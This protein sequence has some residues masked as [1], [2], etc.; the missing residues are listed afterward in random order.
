MIQILALRAPSGVRYEGNQAPRAVESWFDKGLRAPSVDDIFTDPTSFIESVSPSERWNVYYTVSEC[1]EERGRKFSRQWHIPFDVDGIDVPEGIENNPLLLS[2]TARLVCAALGVEFDDT[3]VVYTGNGLQFLIG[4]DQP[5]EDETYFDQA[6][7][8]Y[9]ALCD[10]IDLKLQEHGVRGKADT[11]VW[12]RARLLRYP[13]TLNKKPGKPER[14][15]RIIQPNITRG[16]FKLESASGLPQVA[17]YD[18]INSEVAKTLFTP[19]QAEIMDRDKGCKFLVWAKENPSAVTEPQWYAALSVVA[20]FP[21]GRTAAHD[22]SRGHP[23]YSQSETEIKAKQALEASGPRTCANIDALWGK[24]STCPNFNKYQ[25]PIAIVGESHIKTIN[26]GFYHMTVTQDGRPKRGKPAYEDLLKFFQRKHDYVSVLGSPEIYRWNGK[27]WEMMVKDEILVFA[28]D[29]FDPKPDTKM[30][31]EFYHHLKSTNTVA[32]DFFENR[33]EGVF[34][35]DN[36]VFDAKD[37]TLRPHSKEY[38]FRHVLPCDFNPLADAPRF[39]QFMKE[40]TLS[41]QDLEDVLQEFM[42]Y[43]LSGM[44]PIYTKALLLLGTG[45]NGKSTF[46]N[47]IRELCGEGG[48]SGL[49]LKSMQSD[50]KRYLLMNKLVNIA[51]ENSKDSFKDTELIKNFVSGG[52][53]DVKQLY[54]QPFEYRNKTKLIALMNELPR[55][56]DHTDG[57]WRRM[58]IVPFDANFNEANEKTDLRLED[59][60][61]KEMPGIFNYAIAGLKRLQNAGR[62][63]SS[64]TIRMELENYSIETNDVKAWFME[65]VTIDPS[66]YTQ[67]QAL[68]NGY[69]EYCEKT[70]VRFVLSLIDF[71]RKLR[72]IMKTLGI[73]FNVG[74]HKDHQDG[75]RK[76]DIRG[77]KLRD[78][79][80][81]VVANWAPDGMTIRGREG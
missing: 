24:C 60:L 47:V 79:G 45:A 20:R 75:Q 76:R 71:S 44:T 5:I 3:G 52:W 66:A 36:G 41:R 35:F 2:T 46:I 32:A 39:E 33:P 43:A 57:F 77:I 22:I 10:K 7:P 55:N 14:F 56:A 73:Q 63:T 8:H 30:R 1:L 51:E 21:N 18:Q 25:S 48:H 26:S 28:Q 13:D 23:K 61:K 17:Q 49:S 4:L 9:R 16:S 42:G 12:S 6:R 11:S 50:Q 40:I 27:C 81:H 54:T 19:D 80:M 78:G 74:I 34:N 70:G 59:K 68:Y 31:N 29:H 69:R 67:T 72:M 62:F 65:E 58:L 64:E 53:I 15:A 37:D 38:G